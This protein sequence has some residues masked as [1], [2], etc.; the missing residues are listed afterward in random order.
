MYDEYARLIYPRPDD[1]SDLLLLMMMQNRDVRG[2]R[3]ASEFLDF[4]MGFG[5]S[6]KK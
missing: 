3:N 5:F 6:D 4:V 1:L 2:Q